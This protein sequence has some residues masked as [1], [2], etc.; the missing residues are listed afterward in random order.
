MPDLARDEAA[1]LLADAVSLWRLSPGT[2]NE[3]IDAAVQCLVAGVDSPTLR[4]LAGASPRDSR[5]VLEPLIEDTLDELGMEDVLAVNAQRGAFA[6]V[7]RRFKRNDLSARELVRWAHTNIGHDGD[8]RCQVFV[9]LDDMY[10]TVDYSDDGTEDLDRWT[11]EEVDAYLEGRRSPGRTTVWRTPSTPTA[12]ICGP[13]RRPRQFEVRIS[14]SGRT[15]SARS[16]DDLWCSLPECGVPWRNV[17]FESNHVREQ[18]LK[19]WGEHPD[20]P[21]S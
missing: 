21:A 12:V 11:A 3:V 14:P 13:M 16:W 1:A 9:D 17:S 6:A 7:L 18:V 4:E 15:L 5:F 19:A 8:A 20:A 2:A 10:D